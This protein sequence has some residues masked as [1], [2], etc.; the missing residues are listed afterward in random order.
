MSKST[1]QIIAPT[2][3]APILSGLEPDL[4]LLQL[5][6]MVEDMGLT[7]ML[8]SAVQMRCRRY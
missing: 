1:I 8:I 4:L 2:G 7:P 3:F 5:Q 6:G